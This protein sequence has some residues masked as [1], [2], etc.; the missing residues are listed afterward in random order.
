M[1]ATNNS[2]KINSLN[3]NLTE[4]SLREPTKGELKKILQY[5]YAKKNTSHSELIDPLIKSLPSL[6]SHSINLS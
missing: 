4:N 3:K 5:Y 1:S 2:K 6:E